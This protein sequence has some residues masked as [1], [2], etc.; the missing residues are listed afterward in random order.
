MRPPVIGLIGA[1]GAGKSTVAKLLADC[2]GF[3]IDADALGHAAINRPD[4]LAQLVQRWGPSVA[5]SDGTANRRAIAGIVFRDQTE[6]KALEAVLFPIIGGMALDMIR[7]STAPF[8]AIDAA[9]L[10]EAGW[11]PMCDRVLYVD[12]PREL[13][14]QRVKERGGWSDADL[15][16]RESAQ[17]P[18]E[19]KVAHADA[20]VMNDGSVD[21]LRA[22]IEGVLQAWNL[23]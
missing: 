3:V 12:A 19:A 15:A 2:G 21:D 16:E 10:V 18:A 11:R 14:L 4:V 20:V 1:I 22:K 13:R 6:L 8:I 23:G 5:N 7:T 9:M 17:L